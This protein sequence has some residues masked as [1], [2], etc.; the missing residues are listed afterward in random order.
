MSNYQQRTCGKRPTIGMTGTVNVRIVPVG[1]LVFNMGSANGDTSSF[2]LRSFVN[3]AVVHKFT[4][5]LLSQMLSDG[6][7]E[8]GFTMIDMADSTDATSK[9]CT[10]IRE[11]T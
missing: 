2:L 6:R 4:A 7:G 3:L 11:R 8:S 10:H 5:A 1:S 9:Q